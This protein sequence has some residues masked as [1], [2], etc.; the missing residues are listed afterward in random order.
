MVSSPAPTIERHDRTTAMLTA[1]SSR[2][3]SGRYRAGIV[4]LAA[5]LVAAIGSVGLAQY[6]HAPFDAAPVA[7]SS[8]FGAEMAVLRL[9]AA[10]ALLH[11]GEDA[12]EVEGLLPGL[13]LEVMRF[14]ADLQAIDSA[15]LERV[16]A[17]LDAVL[18]A[19]EDDLVGV[20]E[21]ALLVFQ[22]AR[23]GLV[24]SDPAAD[25]VHTAAIMTLLLTSE[26]GIAEGYEEAVEGEVGAYALGWAGLARAQQLWAALRPS[27]DDNQRF[28][29]DD[30][31]EELEAL[32]TGPLI[33]AAAATADPEEA[34]GPAFRITGY[35]ESIASA[36]LFPNR[37]LAALLRSSLDVAIVG[38]EAYSAGERRVADAQLA[39]VAFAFDE[40]LAGT[41]GMFEPEAT[42]DVTEALA[43]LVPLVEDED[44]GKEEGH[45]GANGDDDDEAEDDESWIALS[46]TEAVTTC[47]TLIDALQRSGA[48]LGL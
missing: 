21:D 35:L 24:P 10:I 2:P 34:E 7:I 42:A 43:L 4:A 22:A 48:V 36:S 44:E 39:W 37:D 47:T 29:I 46:D 28:E 12:Y 17:V 45:A 9:E 25:P 30:M 41:L 38:C 19:D 11:E 27:A 33:P 5:I 32:F 18:A 31:F 20:L 8:S 13:R 26:T 23:A 6:D 15:L 3:R 40:Y 1:D 16:D 14:G